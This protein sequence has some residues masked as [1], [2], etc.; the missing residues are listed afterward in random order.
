MGIF[1]IEAENKVRRLGSLGLLYQPV[2]LS[3]SS[4]STPRFN[5]TRVLL[6]NPSGY[7]TVS[8]QPEYIV[9]KGNT[10]LRVLFIHFCCLMA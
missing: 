5:S 2:G 6:I 9:L 7:L 8:S 10:D 4:V 1:L 3:L